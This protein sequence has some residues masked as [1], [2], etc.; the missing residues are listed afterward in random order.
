MHTH[1]WPSQVWER[2]ERK[3][4]MTKKEKKKKKKTSPSRRENIS[5]RLLI[6][7]GLSEVAP[8]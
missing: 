1:I 8:R 4:Q 7:N 5:K 2:F 3:L 6:P